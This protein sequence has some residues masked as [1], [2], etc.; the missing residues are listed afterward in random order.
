[1]SILNKL[2]GEACPDCKNGYLVERIN[3]Y[4]NNTFLGCS[5]WPECEYT[6]RGGENPAPAKFTY[7]E[8]DCDSDDS[9]CCEGNWDN[10]D[11]YK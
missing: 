10:G 1:M 2:S 8:C 7:N 6:K 5:E 3:S 11:F 9:Y 4:T